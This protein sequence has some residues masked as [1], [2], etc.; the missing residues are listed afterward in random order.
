MP[1]P[2]ILLLCYIISLAI[3][4]ADAIT[5]F[6]FPH[7]LPQNVPL[8]LVM[9]WLYFSVCFLGGLVLFFIAK[10]RGY[11]IT[12]TW[13]IWFIATCV[14]TVV[15]VNLISKYEWKY[16]YANAAIMGNLGLIIAFMISR[17]ATKL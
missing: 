14:V 2:F 10:K 13:A 7:E 4:M 3:C 15:L 6:I 11:N 16:I 8:W 12:N 17:K 5:E 1:K 9:G